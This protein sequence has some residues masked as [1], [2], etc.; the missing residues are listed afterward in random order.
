MYTSAIQVESPMLNTAMHQK[1]R[2]D[3]LPT[4]YGCD[5]QLIQP[6]LCPLPLTW[7]GLSW[8]RCLAQFRAHLMMSQKPDEPQCPHSAWCPEE[9]DR[10]VSVNGSICV[11]VWCLILFFVLSKLLWDLTSS[12]VL[13]LFQGRM[14][15]VQSQM[16]FIFHGTWHYLWSRRLEEK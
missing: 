12:Q 3:T 6:T 7:Q 9:D 14:K 11:N 4:C 2:Y 13:W 1:R 15:S 16:S 8:S 5:F 10:P